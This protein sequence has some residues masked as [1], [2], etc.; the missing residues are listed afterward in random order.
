MTTKTDDF[1]AGLTDEELALLAEEAAEAEAGTEA[2]QE[3]EDAG[4]AAKAAEEEPKAEQTDDEKAAAAAASDDADADKKPAVAAYEN[5]PLI[6]ADA[7]ANAQERLDAIAAEKAALI[8]KFDGGELTT[9]EYTEAL[10]KL[11]DER[12]ELRWSLRKNQL[13]VE[14]TEQQKLDAWFSEVHTFASENPVLQSSPVIWNA[15]DEVVKR[16]G[17]DPATANLPDR[18]GL[19][20]AFR[21]LKQELG[22]LVGGASAPTPA[23]STPPVE[24]HVPP[25]LAHIPAAAIDT[26]A[27]ARF[28]SLDRLS[29]TDPEKY[30]EAFAKMSPADQQRYLAGS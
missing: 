21:I 3:G 5:L 1:N 15:F 9:K 11:S 23:P 28:D 20:L 16:V 13:S 25:T 6:K 4:K 12:D 27:D 2:G 10:E 30:E 26:V 29:N 19:E 14:L 18:E 24:R 7:P 17:S 22:P 8:E